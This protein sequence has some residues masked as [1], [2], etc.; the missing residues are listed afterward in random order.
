MITKFSTLYAGHVD[1]GDMGQDATPANERRYSNEHLASVFEKTEALAR[2][3][4]DLGYYALWLAEHHFQHEGYEA[5]PNIL[6]VAVHLSH[7]TRRLKF[8]C[9]F[10]ITPMWHP[11]RLAEDYATA[12]IL[13]GG[14]TIFGV[15]RGYHTREV[16]TFGAPMLDADANRELFEE[17]VDMGTPKSVMLEQ[18]GAFAREVMPKLQRA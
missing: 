7:V 13:T 1:L 14:R 8:G 4:D 6:M 18:L 5:I 17:Q 2:T 9:G 16:E 12:D 11:L 3:M 15:G 10:N